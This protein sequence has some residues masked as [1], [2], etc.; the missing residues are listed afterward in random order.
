[1]VK[2][3]CYL[4]LMPSNVYKISILYALYVYQV[5]Y[6]E[7]LTRP[8]VHS[9]SCWCWLLVITKP[10]PFYSPRNSRVIW[11]TSVRLFCIFKTMMNCVN[12]FLYANV[13]NSWLRASNFVQQELPINN[14]LWSQRRKTSNLSVSKL[15]TLILCI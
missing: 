8:L 13:N 6:T 3:C 4:I 10:K 9:V 11:V 1:M 14:K 2:C 7:L 12:W 5:L 15:V